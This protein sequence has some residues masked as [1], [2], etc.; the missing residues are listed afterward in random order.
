MNNEIDINKEIDIMVPTQNIFTDSFGNKHKMK[1]LMFG[2]TL[3]INKI[4]NELTQNRTD[5]DIL[6]NITYVDKED[7]HAFLQFV[8][9]AKIISEKDDVLQLFPP[10]DIVRIVLLFFG[11]RTMNCMKDSLANLTKAKHQDATQE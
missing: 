7:D 4:F 10:E 1:I 5:F 9:M 8:E 11:N 6:L 3:K 2:D